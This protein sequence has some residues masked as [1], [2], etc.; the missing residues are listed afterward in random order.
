MKKVYMD[1]GATTRVTEPVFE[2]MRPYFCEVFGNP[3]SM[4]DYGYEAKHAVSAAR[5][6]VAAAIGANPD[7]IYFTGCG[8]ESDNWA[9]RGRGVYEHQARASHI[10]TTAIEHHAM[11][12]TCAAAG[13]RGLSGD[14]SAGGR[15]WPRDA[16]SSWKTPFGRTRPSFR[17][18]TG[19]QRD[20][21]D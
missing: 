18:M 15:I 16:R 10:I 11:L 3:S 21:H 9:V 4:H 6:K 7:E 17:V 20:R 1:N 8:T 5:E 2:A 14:L 12:H 13:K 19:E